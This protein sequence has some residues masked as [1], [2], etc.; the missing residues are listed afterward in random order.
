M[1]QYRSF[2]I[3]GIATLAIL[4]IFLFVP[5]KKKNITPSN[6]PLTKGKSLEQF[7]I[8]YL[9]NQPDSTKKT[10][11]QLQ[12]D[13]E[14]AEDSLT[15]LSAYS[16]SIQ[17]FSQRQ[18]P[19]IASWLVF[20]KAQ[21]LKNTNSWELAGDN[22]VKLLSDMQMDTALFSDVSNHAIRC[23]ENSIQLDS[24]QLNSKMK[25]AQ[26]YMELTNN[27][28]SG[29]Q[30]LLGIVKNN[31]KNIDAQLLLAKFGLVSGQVEKVQQRLE[32]VLSLQP[33]N[34]DALLMRAEAYARTE[35]LELA[36]KDLETV[37]NNAKTPNAMK[38]QLGMAIADLEAKRKK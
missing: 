4:V 36:I 31:P 27:P 23:Y 18:V 13:I 16:T 7:Y 21:Y 32:T 10:I 26:C 3:Y 30:L 28:M 9:Q 22:F 15:K 6:E 24:N 19:E 2:I 29:V 37:K 33:Q 12:A 14:S 1:N 20:Q 38:E 11:Y 25:L 5:T 8:Q 34:L 35:K 17:Y